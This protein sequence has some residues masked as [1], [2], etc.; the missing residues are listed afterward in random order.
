M[1]NRFSPA[2]RSHAQ[3]N[4]AQIT[5]ILAVMD[6]YD[7]ALAEADGVEWEE[8]D[9]DEVDLGEDVLHIEVND[10]AEGGE[11][12]KGKG[13]KRR[14]QEEEGP[15]GC[16][17]DASVRQQ[18]GPSAMQCLLVRIPRER[19]ATVGRGKRRCIVC[20]DLVRR[21]FAVHRQ[22]QVR[23]LCHASALE[24]LASLVQA[25]FQTNRLSP[26]AGGP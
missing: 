7:D 3:Q 12:Q 23:S 5:S 9:A 22:D 14:P 4:S 16:A 2:T 10:R 25:N 21:A 13:K 18:G 19:A 26:R 1:G 20:V 6:W 11:Q 17:C 24:G 15:Q 8:P